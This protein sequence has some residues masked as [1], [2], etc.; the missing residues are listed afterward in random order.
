MAGS[1][2]NDF[3]DSNS[4]PLVVFTTDDQYLRYA[5]TAANMSQSFSQGSLDVKILCTDPIPKRNLI[6]SDEHIELFS[7]SNHVD[8][9]KNL[10]EFQRSFSHISRAM[11]ARLLL[12][13]LFPNQ[14]FCIYLDVDTMPTIDLRRLWFLRKKNYLVQGV[15]RGYHPYLEALGFGEDSTY[16]NSGV[17]LMNL[18]LWRANKIGDQI[19]NKIR[20]HES[21]LFHPDQ[22]AINLICQN[23]I[24]E[25][26]IKF[27]LNPLN[28]EPNVPQEL[29]LQLNQE[30]SGAVFH[31]YGKSKPW[32]ENFEI[33][34]SRLYRTFFDRVNLL[35]YVMHDI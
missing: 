33:R 7:I 29:V 32:M 12:P 24:G 1:D 8:Q 18:N 34:W 23:H 14:E 35:R 26:P 15:R 31:F 25:L 5:L 9:L 10:P 4:R 21:S 11:Y 30:M 2:Q 13:S 16:V 19:I 27:N 6:A 17:L 22:D 28:P 3:K 20:E